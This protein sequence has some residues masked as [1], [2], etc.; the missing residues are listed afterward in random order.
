MD[1]W[2]ILIF[3]LGTATLECLG[4]FKKPKAPTHKPGDVPALHNNDTTGAFT[5]L[6][7]FIMINQSLDPLA[8]P[9]QKFAVPMMGNVEMSNAVL[10]GLSGL[11]RTGLVYLYVN[12]SG[13]ML[14]VDVGSGELTMNFTTKMKVMFATRQM[15]VSVTTSSSHV[16]LDVGET[17][18]RKLQLEKFSI[19]KLKNL[20]VRVITGG[21]G[22]TFLSGF[23][24]GVTAAFKRVIRSTAEREVRKALHNEIKK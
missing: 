2:K 11:R 22:G 14:H 16:I 13:L 1:V 21:F 20:R 6:I 8:I 18:D 4:S 9:T 17:M 3:L 12:D 24:K 23:L 7:Q 5:K 15:N 10:T 19:V